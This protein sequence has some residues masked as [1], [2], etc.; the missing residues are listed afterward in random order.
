MLL[1]IQ[2]GVE[3]N[4]GGDLGFLNCGGTL[5]SRSSCPGSSPGGNIALFS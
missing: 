4:I 1:A 3:G 2:L 5:V